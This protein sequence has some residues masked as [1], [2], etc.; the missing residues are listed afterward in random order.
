[1]SRLSCFYDAMKAILKKP[2]NFRFALFDSH[3]YMQKNWSDVSK[4]VIKNKNENRIYIEKINLKPLTWE[5]CNY[6]KFWKK[7]FSLD[8]S[9]K[10]LQLLFPL[11]APLILYIIV[12]NFSARSFYGLVCLDIQVNSNFPKCIIQRY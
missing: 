5:M 6:F 12:K 2:S 8:S 7:D 10:L 1:M 9:Y 3:T 4:I 11:T